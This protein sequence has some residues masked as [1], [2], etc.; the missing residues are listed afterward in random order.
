MM[1]CDS[2]MLV[3]SGLGVITVCE[4]SKGVWNM[5]VAAPERA[6]CDA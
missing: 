3:I 5:C 4:V 2:C 1:F 6:M